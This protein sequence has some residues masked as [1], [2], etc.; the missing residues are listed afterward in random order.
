[1]E[2]A[3]SQFARAIRKQELQMQAVELLKKLKR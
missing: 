2:E 1:M 3:P